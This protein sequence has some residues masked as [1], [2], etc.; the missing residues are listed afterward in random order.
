LLLFFRKE[1]SSFLL[2]EH[3]GALAGIVGR[4]Q[5]NA[6]YQV[7]IFIQNEETILHDTNALGV[8]GNT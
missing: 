5:I 2:T 8:K 1:V 3:E 7:V 4:Q 6:R